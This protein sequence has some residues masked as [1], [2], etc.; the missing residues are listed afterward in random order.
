M[1]L[2]RHPPPILILSVP[3]SPVK[4]KKLP[5][6]YQL[7]QLQFTSDRRGG[8][9]CWRRRRRRRSDEASESEQSRAP[10]NLQSQLNSIVGLNPE[11]V[12]IAH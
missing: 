9:R 4:R 11:H 12:S 3:L 7:V 8:P 2:P 1:T 6:L 5:L 10:K